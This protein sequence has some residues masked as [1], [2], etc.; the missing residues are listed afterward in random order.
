MALLFIMKGFRL[1]ALSKLAC[2]VLPIEAR[3]NNSDVAIKFFSS[4]F[5]AAR[6]SYPNDVVFDPSSATNARLNGKFPDTNQTRLKHARNRHFSDNGIPNTDALADLKEDVHS[7]DVVPQASPDKHMHLHDNL[8]LHQKQ[9]KDR[10]QNLM[11]DHL[12]K[13]GLL[14][15]NGHTAESLS[16]RDSKKVRH[17]D[18]VA[19]PWQNRVQIPEVQQSEDGK[20]MHTLQQRASHN[21]QQLHEGHSLKSQPGEPMHSKS[22]T[23]VIGSKPLKRLVVMAGK[24]HRKDTNI[25]QLRNGTGD[26]I[27]VTSVND[28]PAALQHHKKHIR[29][30]AISVQQHKKVIR[31]KQPHKLFDFLLPF[32]FLALFALMECSEKEWCG[33]RKFSE[34]V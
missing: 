33:K 23:Q 22:K 32:S 31:M 27:N 24:T 25:S 10:S 5:D 17:G 16:T 29:K 7:Q 19:A 6:T 26:H 1:V 4:L 34:K 18:E 9:L 13:K 28:R 3:T 20:L 2:L 15:L 30:D 21:H 12:P 14:S 8:R 11:S